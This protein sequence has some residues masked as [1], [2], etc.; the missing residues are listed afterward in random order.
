[1]RLKRAR[2][3]PGEL[4]ARVL[5]LLVGSWDAVGPEEPGEPCSDFWEPWA[6]SDQDLADI[7]ARHRAL[8]DAEARRRS[9]AR[10]HIAEQITLWRA[11][12]RTDL[13]L[14]AVGE[15]R[16]GTGAER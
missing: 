5:A 9:L 16:Q 6:L 13:S 12:G 7:Y 8:V 3:P 11:V 14:G 15:A 1:M 2:R 10:P 4:A